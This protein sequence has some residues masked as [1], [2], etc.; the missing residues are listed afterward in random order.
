MAKQPQPKSQSWAAGLSRSRFVT[1]YAISIGL[2]LAVVGA[3]HLLTRMTLLDVDKDTELVEVSRQQPLLTQ[4]IV[5]LTDRISTDPNIQDMRQLNAAISLF[6]ANHLRL[7][8]EPRLP[9]ALKARFHEYGQNSVDPLAERLSEL[10]R[11]VA[12]SEPPVSPDI[13]GEIRQ[14]ASL[15]LLVPLEEIVTVLQAQIDI[16]V[17]DLAKMQLSAFSF[18]VLAILAEV[19]LILRPA[20][21]AVFFADLRARAL[22]RRIKRLDR[23]AN[24]RG[25]EG[26]ALMQELESARSRHP[27]SG[28]INRRQMIAEID[29]LL[30]ITD[31]PNNALVSVLTVRVPRLAEVHDIF[32]IAQ[33][34][35]LVADLGRSLEDLGPEGCIVAQL[36]GETLA[37][38]YYGTTEPH[39]LCEGIVEK[40][41][42]PCSIGEETYRL[43]ATIGWNQAVPQTTEG[44]TLLGDAMVA[45]HEGSR[46]TQGPHYLY[47]KVMRANQL[48]RQGLWNDLQAGI[49]R[50]E[51]Q[52][53]FQPQVRLDGDGLSGLEML[54]RWRHPE[55]GLMLPDQFLD[56]AGEAGLIG[57][58]DEIVLTNGLDELARLRAE[59]WTVPAVSVNLSAKTLRDPG[60]VDKLLWDLEMRGLEAGDLTVEILETTLMA[61]ATDAGAENVARLKKAGFKIELD[62]FGVGYASFASLSQLE[63]QGIKLDRSLIKALPDPGSEAIVRAIIGMA[64]ELNL[65]VTAEGVETPAHMSLL[66]DLGCDTAQ[67]FGISKPMAADDLVGWLK[68]FDKGPVAATG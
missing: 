10:A 34:S 40:I 59:G 9:P 3:S 7:K 46:T 67:G 41:G 65:S 16:K 45:L 54:A 51:F 4:R 38:A 43:G 33:T 56:L 60:L 48:A 15:T 32:S 22:R 12:G 39:G 18:V 57:R 8:S 19:T 27:D 2:V 6:E 24:S 62:D 26:E 37:L 55:R 5:Y 36:D 29:W 68:A 14:L 44:E 50:H 11:V 30:N 31:G 52:A 17:A 63:V 21:R 66:Q 49:E 58:I 23:M 42:Q 53:F 28:L 64:R 61:V 25:A 35:A 13:L 47:D 20:M 1:R